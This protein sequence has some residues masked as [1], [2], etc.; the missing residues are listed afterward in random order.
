MSA[1]ALALLLAG[2]NLRSSRRWGQLQLRGVDGVAFRRCDRCQR[3]HRDGGD[4]SRR[5]RRHDALS[6]SGFAATGWVGWSRQFWRARSSGTA[7]SPASGGAVLVA[8]Y[9]AFMAVIRILEPQPPALG[10]T[11][12]L[13]QHRPEGGRPGRTTCYSSWVWRQ[14]DRRRRPRPRVR[15]RFRHSS[16]T[17]EVAQDSSA[18]RPTRRTDARRVGPSRSL[19]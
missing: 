15:L 3:C 5:S 14:S 19:G 13:H 11:A 4:R 16:S 2:L 12:E 8:G 17:S 10:E 7:T 1:F 9:M 18:R 6:A